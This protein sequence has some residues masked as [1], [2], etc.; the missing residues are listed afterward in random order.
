MMAVRVPDVLVRVS[1]LMLERYGSL[2]VAGAGRGRAVPLPITFSRAD[3]STSATY[4]DRDGF[5]RK[6]AANVMRLEFADLDGDA[7]RETP[8]ILLEGSRTND[9]DRSEEMDHANWTKTA[10]TVN[11]NVTVAPDGTTSSDDII[12][13]VANSD[14]S[15]SRNIT[16]FTDNTRYTISGWSKSGST[17][18]WLVLRTVNKA[19]SAVRTWFNL[20]TGTIGTKEAGHDA[21]MTKVQST[22]GTWYRCSVTFDM[23]TGATTPIGQFALATGDGVFTYTGDGTSGLTLWGLAVERQ[24]GSFG[25]APFPSSYIKTTTAAIQRQADS[26]TVPFNFGP[27]DLTVLQRVTRPAHAD[28][29]GD[30]GLEPATF[31][32]STIAGRVRGNFQQSSRFLRAYVDAPG[33]GVDVQQTT[34]IPA[35][36]SISIC[37]QFRNLTSTGGITKLDVGSGYT[38]DSSAATAFSAFGN[39]TLE[40]GM[41]T[42]SHV[43][44]GGLIDLIIA[45]GLFTKAEMEAIP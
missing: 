45:R 40:I 7:I 34:A 15:V 30:L 8:G 14:H 17:R 23:G 13:T 4:V 10:V 31:T 11:A 20:S 9:W 16:G 22:N 21:S 26:F 44:H 24:G 25:A 39:Q 33:G 12:E 29:T 27:M 19:N 35:G 32:L 43:L 6:A 18:S 2:A 42:T 1:P 3:A 38:A 36:A 5:I 28:V 37:S 41:N